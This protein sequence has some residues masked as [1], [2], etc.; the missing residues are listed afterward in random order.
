MGYVYQEQR[1]VVFTDEGQRLLLKV[2]DRAVSLLEQAGAFTIG[3]VTRGISGD[4]WEL[5]ACVDRLVEL[6]E[7]RYLT[8][9]FNV[10]TQNKVLT[11]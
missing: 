4:S 7:C 5:L 1:K 2:R 8:D 9:E 11:R 3:K 10:A 6:G